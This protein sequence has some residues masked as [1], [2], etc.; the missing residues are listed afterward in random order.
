MNK[1]SFH[2]KNRL[3]LYAAGAV[4]VAA[5]INPETFFDIAGKALSLFSP[6]IIG[7]TA[8]FIMNKPVCAL[9]NLSERLCEK[10]PR[11][12]C[13]FYCISSDGTAQSGRLNRSLWIFSL[14]AAYI[15]LA[16]VIVG[17]FMII[18]PQLVLSVRMLAANAEEYRE[19]LTE[20]YN[21]LAAR[22]TTGII[23]SISRAFS[24]S[25]D[26]LAEKLPD[27]AAAAY[28]KTADFLMAAADLVIGLVISVYI[29]ADKEK[30][31]RLVKSTAKKILTPDKYERSAARYRLTYD[32]FTKFVIGQLAEGLI[33][34]LLC[35]VGMT[36]LRFE[37]PLL[38]ST[39]IGITA[40]VPIAGT[41][42]GTIPCAFLLFLV[43]PSMAVWFIIFIIILQQLDNN[44]IYP[45]VV[46]K[47]MGLPPLPVLLAILFGAKIGGAAGILLAVPLT[48]VIFALI[49]SD[50]D[51]QTTLP[52][53]QRRA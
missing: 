22:D 15:L 43:K 17:I 26:S 25:A 14:T 5:L 34:G 47:S 28:G 23:R 16:A 12:I 49:N 27:I 51:R 48:A 45:R 53:P 2:D 3:W 35:F 29:L 38:I 46:G 41:L 20:Y 6:V 8:A 19:K 31:C 21:A 42:I 32:I 4:F 40:L 1:H 9:Y 10:K 44:L 24:A 39:I 7:M 33:L 18:I 30:M 11:R 50:N 13:P 52:Q 36:L 37:Y